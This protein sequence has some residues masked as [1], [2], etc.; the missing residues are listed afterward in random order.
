MSHNI[1]SLIRLSALTCLLLCGNGIGG[2]QPPKKQQPPES[3]DVAV[4]EG[5][6]RVSLERVS[7]KL[8]LIRVKT[9][10]NDSVTHTSVYRLPYPVYRFDVGDVTGDGV[11]DI[12]VGVIKTTT[13]H[14]VMAKRPFL[15]K[16]NENGDIRKLWM[17][18][19][20]SQPLEDFAL[21]KNETPSRILTVERERSGKFLVAVYRWHGFGLKHEE[22][23]EREVPLK[24]AY[25][26]LEEYKRA[27]LTVCFTGDVMLDR[28]VRNKI[29][30]IGIDSIF[31]DAK[32]V[33]LS[34]DAV[35][36]NLENPV[37][38]RIAPLNKKYVF[39]AEPEWLPALRKLGITHA[40]MANN[41]TVDQ[42]R[43]GITDTYNN[44]TA[45]NITPVGYGVNQQE[46]CKPSIIEKKGVPVKVA[47]FNSFLL[48][49]DDWTLLENEAG[50]CQASVEK[51]CGDIK[52]FKE[53][54]PGYRAVAVLHWGVEHTKE[55]TERQRTD[56]RR[57]V[58]SGADAVVGHHPHVIQDEE[59]YNGAPI[60]Y[61]IGNFAFDQRR[62][63]GE[64]DAGLAIKLIFSG[65]GGTAVERRF[66]RIP[67]F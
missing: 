27:S 37:T 25:K 16:I 20:V 35:V 36:I 18:S 21:T 50:V 47:I 59:T 39:R 64:D 63:Q 2:P 38:K 60:F 33:F 30:R 65:T 13:Y 10:I 34:S 6:L 15:F 19:R 53:S 67:V 14:P 61:S 40:A 66:V 44:L 41:H 55:P 43:E 22:Y 11:P 26:L 1:S 3:H 9:L 49:V 48:S 24:K 5:T 51:I 4:G 45:S 57:L 31:K 54:H 23:I 8:N 29:E 17:G 56:A 46:A 32:P 42:G 12:A 52:A 28:G 7:N 62:N 58:D